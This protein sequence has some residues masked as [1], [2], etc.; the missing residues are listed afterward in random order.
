MIILKSEVK[1]AVVVK[2]ML[3]LQMQLPKVNVDKSPSFIKYLEVT[4]I[5]S[6]KLHFLTQFYSW[7]QPLIKV[8][9]IVLYVPL[10]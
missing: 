7:L 8:Y 3:K 6:N 2:I 4:M 1:E 9:L 10:Q 5:L